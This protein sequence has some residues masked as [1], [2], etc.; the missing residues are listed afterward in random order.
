ML[1]NQETELIIPPSYTTQILLAEFLLT[2][3]TPPIEY[4][5]APFTFLND[6]YE[7]GLG[8][9]QLTKLIESLARVGYGG[10]YLHPRPGLITEYFSDRWF[11]L[12]RHCIT[13]CHRC[14]ITPHLYDENSY[15]SGFS[16][17][18]VP[19]L[20]PEARSRYVTFI[21]GTGL[22]YFPP[23]YLALYSWVNDAPLNPLQKGEISD[24]TEWVAF[25]LQDLAPMA[26]H[27]E[28]VY[29][30]L[31]DPRTTEAFLET[32]YERYR[33]ELGELWDATPSIFTDEPHLPGVM[34][35]PWS[36]GL[37]LTPY[38]L[39]QFRQKL[40]Y[41]LIDHLS[42]L[43]FDVGDFRKI[44]Y[45][46]YDLCHHLWFE[47]WALPLERWCHRHSIKLTGHYLEH[48]W[49][50]PYAT[51]GHVHLLAHMDWP[52]SDMLMGYLLKGHDFFDIQGFEPSPPGRESHGLYFLRQIHSIANQLGKERV[53]NESW[54]AG[55]SE[56]APE[57][58]MRIGR[59]MIIHGVNL[60][61]P[62]SSWDTIRGGRK[63]D[64]PPNFAPQS[65]WFDYLAP[66]NDE[67]ARLCWAANQGECV[68]RILLIDSLTSGYCVSRKSESSTP[69][70]IQA[71]GDPLFSAEESLP[72]IRP[73]KFA[74]EELA[75]NLS[76]AFVDF[77][78]G[79][80]YVLEESGSVSAQGLSIGN[81][82]YRWIVLPPLLQNL[83]ASTARMLREALSEGSRLFGIHP[84]EFYIDGRPSTLLDDL[85][86]SFPTQV[87][88]C[89]NPQVLQE[90]LIQ[91]VPPRLTSKEAT[92]FIGLAHM[93][94]ILENGEII[95]LVNS[96]PEKFSASM[97]LRTTRS[98]LRLFSP[99][100]GKICPCP[101][102]ATSGSLEFSIAI[103]AG[104]AAILFV[105]DDI[106]PDE[107]TPRPESCRQ[108][109]IPE[110]PEL[111]RADRLSDNIM[112][113]DFCSLDLRG[114]IT[115]PE[116]VTGAN[117]RYWQAN[118]METNGWNNLIQYRDQIL[119]RDQT[120]RSDSGG[121]VR[122]EFVIDPGVDLSP[123]RLAVECPELWA[124]EVNGH[125]VS[126][127]RENCFRDPRIN[128][129]QVGAHLRHGK[130][131]VTLQG[132]PFTVRQEIDQI[133]LLGDFACDPV[134]IGFRLTPPRS[135]TWGSWK[136]Q[137]LPFYDAEVSYRLRLPD[138][139]QALHFP[140]EKWGGALI[141]AFHEGQ[142]IGRIYEAPWIIDLTGHHA[143]T[144]DIRIVGL[145]INLFGPWHD[146]GHRWGVSNPAM[147]F[148][149]SVD[150]RPQPGSQY[151]QIDLGLFDSPVA[152]R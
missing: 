148:G 6:E 38:V 117:L 82:N 31:L 73:L 103:D 75:Q 116:C 52:G 127:L 57:D 79:D 119:A 26:W 33:T 69:A 143:D 97:S 139:T 137:G 138:G 152:I 62:H 40:R 68:N 46:F 56:T 49:P 121:T 146:A 66:L 102:S 58:W 109:K 93:H 67:L 4:R 32:T 45:D 55:G 23:S 151:L 47:N 36:P 44:R 84:G 14:G 76:E 53:I 140:R 124:V 107:T 21:Q 133:Y 131:E 51:P 147:W 136:S 104:G 70:A 85:Q 132:R 15:P 17:G 87:E 30:S 7:P 134:E 105:T 8:E 145:P 9:A 13:E 65:P 80:E 83:R 86:H 128:W 35:G 120:M 78:I 135:L 59:W 90:R 99:S 150:Q 12:I 88:W 122:Y 48:D 50:C 37:H 130:N 141:L 96:S 22:Q 27:G 113:I 20:V 91:I 11:E 118:G 100:T 129:A 142:E 5:P 123:L 41:E 10:A 63:A 29:P 110:S 89:E 149:E 144:I 43:F 16:G 95:L 98:S 61:I 24:E 74:A 81:R 18:H 54:G 2:F 106:L 126:F 64:H 34:H 71:Y 28:T 101:A 94:R 111:L 25:T 92:P 108:V 19:A 114:K 39:G 3:S 42:S 125:S 1:K 112:A 115:P 77:D 72:S 60:I